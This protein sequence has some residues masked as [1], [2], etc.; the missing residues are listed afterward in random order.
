MVHVIHSSQSFIESL[1]AGQT[2]AAYEAYSQ[3]H[4]TCCIQH[5]TINA[6][7]YLHTIEDKYM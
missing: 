2:V 6:M 3:M 5:Y 4:G 7:L 1:F